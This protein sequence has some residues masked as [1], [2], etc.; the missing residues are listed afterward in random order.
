MI[1]FIFS[2]VLIDRQQRRWRLSQH[3]GSE[4][5]AGWSRAWLD[6]EPYQASPGPGQASERAASEKE[7]A[8]AYSGWYTRKKKRA[9]ARME[10]SDAF[11]MRGRVV[12]ALVVWSGLVLWGTAYVLRCMYGWILGP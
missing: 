11:E 2:L 1:S 4:A 9:M 10:I 7:S 12:V 3:S 8:N 5:T 6:P